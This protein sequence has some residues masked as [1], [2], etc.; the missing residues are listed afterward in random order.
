MLRNRDIGEA[1]EK[2]KARDDAVGINPEIQILEPD[3][4]NQVKFP[5]IHGVYPVRHKEAASQQPP[6]CVERLKLT[7]I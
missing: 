5:G 3:A 7:A 4:V 6:P 1:Y 2:I